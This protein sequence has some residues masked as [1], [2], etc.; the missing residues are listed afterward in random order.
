MADAFDLL[1]DAV[2]TDKGSITDY[3]TSRG[4]LFGAGFEESFEAYNPTAL[5]GRQM[6]YL[7]E[8]LKSL[9]GE[10]ER[11]D[12]KTA[13][14]EI[15]KR[16]LDL[17]VP[18]GGM[19]RVE[20]DSLQY[21]KQRE[22]ARQSTYAR[23]RPIG[24]TASLLGGSLA[25]AAVDPIN[26]ASAF[27]PIV[28]EARY[29]QWL[30]R[31][32]EGAFARAGVR[33][34]AGA[35]E[36]AAG[37]AIIEPI[38]YAGATS[39]QADYGLMDSFMNVTLGGVLGGGL[40]TIGGGIYDWGSMP[41]GDALAREGVANAP[42]HV[43]REAMQAA[44]E[45]LERGEPVDVEEML[46]AYHGSPHMFERFDVSKI[47]TGEGAQAFGHGLYFAES[48]SVAKHYQEQLGGYGVVSIGG[49]A[50]NAADAVEN[51]IS[52]L[53]THHGGDAKAAEAQLRDLAKSSD[54]GQADIFLRAADRVAAGDVAY[55][56]NANMYEVNIRARVDELLDWDRPLKDQPAAIKKA[57]VDI[58]KSYADVFRTEFG[59]VNNA[60]KDLMR[61]IDSEHL[62]GE[63]VLNKLT[64]IG[65]GDKAMVS[66]DLRAA[67]LR[68][69]QYL[70]QMSRGRGDGTRNFVI[71]DDKDVAI[72][73]RNGEPVGG[74]TGPRG[75]SDLI[76]EARA[77][78]TDAAFN[79]QFVD[80]VE[81]IATAEKAKP[82]DKIE[83]A[84]TEGEDWADI[85]EQFREQGRV[86]EAD[87]AAL[88]QADELGAWAE[89]RAKAFEAAASCL[90]VA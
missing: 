62:T 19:T 90:T 27:I 11:V 89:R 18:V 45:A 73:S 50:A 29:A 30:A 42:E 23:P 8:D 57:V 59:G 52:I 12:Q 4:E 1:D 54:A 31:A 64:E 83:A 79:R 33:A 46:R 21:L 53:M 40:H 44:V 39:E 49:R 15:A 85:V 20:L 26:V 17:K 55:V 56:P 88:K 58:A 71:F 74:R 24:G 14:A 80:Q 75:L 81:E 51:N 65:G 3:Q 72:V 34:G 82:K 2:T 35:I 37:A 41:V 47:G 5:I 66:A 77:D 38:V 76:P 13:Q 9:T 63:G 86:T 68:G 48:A 43:K 6:R 70:D 87:D 69:I 7:D 25:G 60:I 61:L 84:K 16:G 32:G 28:P 67:G 22:L 10:S 36:G 78:R